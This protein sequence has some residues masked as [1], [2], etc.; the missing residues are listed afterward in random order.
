MDSEDNKIKSKKINKKSNKKLNKKDI[1]TELDFYEYEKDIFNYKN[2]QYL[3]AKEKTDFDN[4]FS[5][6]RN[7]SQEK[8]LKYLKNKD[9]RIVIASG[10]AGTGKTLFACQHAICSL[11]T[12]SR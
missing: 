3:S 12:E 4:K 8:F 10:P 6:P 9:Y 7:K 5:V 1:S 11:K 2:I